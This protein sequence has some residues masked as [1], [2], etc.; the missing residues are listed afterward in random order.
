MTKTTKNIRTWADLAE[1]LRTDPAFVAEARK[2]MT[3]TDKRQ[4][5]A[6]YLARAEYGLN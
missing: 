4:E 2:L 6:E 3:E 5:Y 1:A